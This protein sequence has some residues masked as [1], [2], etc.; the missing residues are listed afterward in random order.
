MGD[1]ERISKSVIARLQMKIQS[2]ELEA[3]EAQSRLETVQVCLQACSVFFNSKLVTNRP[4]T[5]GENTTTMCSS[6]N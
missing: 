2:L 5:N 3:S 6:S 1:E 4:R